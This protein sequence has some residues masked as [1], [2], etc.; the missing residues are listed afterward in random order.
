[1]FEDGQL[2]MGTDE[3]AEDLRDA[4]DAGHLPDLDVDYAAPVMMAIGI[5]LGLRLLERDPPDVDGATRFA[6]GP[7]AARPARRQLIFISRS[8][9]APPGSAAIAAREL[10]RG[11]DAAAVAS[12]TRP[13]RNASMRALA[14]AC[15]GG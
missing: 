2:P 12:A 15:A 9:A 14:D 4:I 6:T 3:L 13:R 10:L 5:E 8:A 1:M 11:E 7:A